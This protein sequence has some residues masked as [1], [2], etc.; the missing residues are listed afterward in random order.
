MSDNTESFELGG[1][2]WRL[3]PCEEWTMEQD[4]V[5]AAA[6]LEAAPMLVGAQNLLSGGDLDPVRAAITTKHVPR[7]LMAICY[8]P[9]GEA[10]DAGK[11][12]D[13]MAELGSLKGAAKYVRRAVDTFFS[14]IASLGLTDSRISSTEPTSD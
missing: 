12:D 2:T 7:R 1:K 8:W 10:F 6:V 14:F 11:I 4:E 13:H 3:M 9:E 5:A